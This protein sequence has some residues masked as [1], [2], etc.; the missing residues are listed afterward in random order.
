MAGVSKYNTET[1]IATSVSVHGQKYDYTN[2]VFIPGEKPK[3]TLRCPVH[4]MITMN[5]D[6]HLKGSGCTQCSRANRVMPKRGAY[7]NT[8]TENSFYEKAD[9]IHAG[10][11][12]FPRG[13]YVNTTVP[14]P[15]ICA[16][17]GTVMKSPYL[18]LRGHGCPQCYKATINQNKRGTFEQFE[19]QARQ[20]HGDKFEYDSST[21]VGFKKRMKMR[22]TV[23][24][25][26]FWKEPYVHLRGSGCPL[27]N[28]SVG[29]R[30]VGATLDRLGVEYIAEFS[31]PGYRYEY[32][33]YLPDYQLFIEFHGTH[34]YY[35]NGKKDDSDSHLVV[36]KRDN[37]KASMVKTAG[38][39]MVVFDFRQLDN[40][41]L[42]SAVEQ[43]MKDR[44]KKPRDI[45]FYTHW[46]A[47]QESLKPKA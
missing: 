25:Q 6:G 21:F 42:E 1:A 8:P 15:G 27:C 23:D 13:H 34:H 11:L 39:E 3:L 2:S 43:L 18:F 41:T 7:K 46:L 5:L 24:K 45:P 16:S 26:T 17:H 32:D 22:C 20:L 9:L 10:K 40:K 44:P 35:H 47:Y 30:L 28:R 12:T 14:V 38:A 33:F 37:I 19:L 29:E 36:Q 31:F 4:G